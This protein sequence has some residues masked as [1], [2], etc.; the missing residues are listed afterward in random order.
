MRTIDI[1]NKIKWDKSENPKETFVFYFD[2]IKNQL[3]KIPF[4][5]I[6]EIGKSFIMIEKDGEEVEIPIHRIKEIRRN[7]KLI[8]SRMDIL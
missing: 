8:W 3:L 1:L 7:S 2:R 4:E 6:K 5:S